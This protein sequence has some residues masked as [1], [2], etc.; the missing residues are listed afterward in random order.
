MKDPSA[1]YQQ[2][3]DEVASL[4]QEIKRLKRLEADRRKIGEKLENRIASLTQPMN[5]AGAVEFEDM[6][7][8][9]EMQRLQDELCSAFGVAALL[10]RTDGTPI[11]RPSNFSRFCR[12]IV[13]STERGQRKC[14]TS[15][16]RLGRYHSE[17][18]IVQPCLSAGLW[19]AGASITVGGGSI[20]PIGSS[21]R[22]ATKPKTRRISAPM[23]GNSELTRRHLSKPSTRCR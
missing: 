15:D 16:A 11:T 23:P 6:F 18:P 5:D 10:T 17:G 1:T 20:S 19:G 22:S 2:L 7:D 4:K 14:Q 3:V 8:L 13:R 21:A 12:D 9:D